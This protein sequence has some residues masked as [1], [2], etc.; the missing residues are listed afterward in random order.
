[1]RP[2]KTYLETPGFLKP[3]C[4]W[5]LPLIPGLFDALSTLLAYVALNLTAASVWQISRG[6][7]IVT[8]AIFSKIFLHKDLTLSSLIG[9]SLAFFG[10]TLVQIFE[11]TLSS[12]SV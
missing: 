4:P 11:I 8:T 9:C 12:G 2:Q 10:I 7:V 1:L 6:G 5:Y 3:E